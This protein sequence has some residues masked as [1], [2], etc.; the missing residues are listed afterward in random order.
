LVERLAIDKEAIRRG[1]RY[2]FPVTVAELPGL[3]E[4]FSLHDDITQVLEVAQ[5]VAPST[6]AGGWLDVA[7]GRIFV[8]ATEPDGPRFD[9]VRAASRQAGTV[10]IVTFKHT[11]EALEDANNQIWNDR[12]EL[13][14]QGLEVGAAFVNVPLNRL[15]IAVSGGNHEE[16]AKRLSELFGLPSDMLSVTEYLGEVL[17]TPPLGGQSIETCSAGPFGHGGGLAHLTTAGHCGNALRHNNGG[18]PGALTH[19]PTYN[20]SLEQASGSADAQ[21]MGPVDGT[22]FLVEGWGAADRTIIGSQGVGG[23]FDQVGAWVCQSGSR[24]QGVGNC[25][26]IVSVDFNCG[27]LSNMRAVDYD[28]TGGDSGATV[29][30]L[31]S[32]LTTRVVG[33]HQG[34]CSDLPRYTWHVNARSALGLGGWYYDSNG[35]PFGFLDSATRVAGGI[36]VTGW[37]IEPN[38]LA[39]TSVHVY[40]DLTGFNIGLAATSRPDVAAQYPVYGPLH[41]FA[42]TLVVPAGPNYV[43][44]YGINTA[45]WGGNALLTSCIYVP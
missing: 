12:S 15:S 18:L 40:V 7:N 44:A 26:P 42:T 17:D 27:G 37:T 31:P 28:R 10:E 21:R 32:N 25:G 33:L 3:D 22:T 8:G 1:D 11:L 23:T 19:D 5:A 36:R 43:C 41:G 39:S 35:H 2:G 34:V 6:Y 30:S 24:T 16:A 45:S 9:P 29:Y 13:G 4:R 14:R 20:T 38:S